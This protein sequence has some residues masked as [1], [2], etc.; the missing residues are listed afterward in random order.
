MTSIFHHNIILILRNLMS[1][2]CDLQASPSFENPIQLEHRRR[3]FSMIFIHET[4][5]LSMVRSITLK[6]IYARSSS[7][8]L[9]PSSSPHS[10]LHHSSWK[11][12]LHPTDSLKT[13]PFQI[14]LSI[15]SRFQILR[16]S[17]QKTSPF[18]FCKFQIPDSSKFYPENISISF[19]T[20][21]EFQIL[22][23]SK[24]YPGKSPF[25][26]FLPANSRFRIPQ[27]SST[28]G[29]NSSL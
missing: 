9:N 13:S 14:L 3:D 10:Q 12:P 24:F 7:R 4:F 2:N 18:P 6:F 22:D 21:T 26:I 19:I 16:N 1:K 11:V 28:P 15:N 17:T 8:I 23:S 29:K 27:N 25:P 20:L 5:R